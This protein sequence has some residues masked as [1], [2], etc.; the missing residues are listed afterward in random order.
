VT[1]RVLE[2]AD[3]PARIHVALESLQVD[4]P[5][6][7]PV[8]IPLEDL[9]VLVLSHPQAQITSA[10]LQAIA[11][12]GGAVLVCDAKHQPAGLLLPLQ[13]HFIQAERMAR[14]AAVAL[15]LKK[16]LWQQII[17]AKVGAQANLL[18]QLRGKDEGLGTL[19]RQIRSGDAGNLEAQAARRYWKALFE[20]SEFKR[21]REAP[22]QNRFL[23]YGY[24]VLRAQVARSICASGLHPALGLQH[25][26]R[27]SA[28]PLAD[29][30]MEPYRPFVDVVAVKLS[31]QIDAE[32]DMTREIRA[33]LLGVLHARVS[34]GGEQL[35]LSHAVLKSAQSL[36]S[37]LMG[38]AR[39]LQFPDP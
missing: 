16:R 31:E 22:D 13:G 33:E 15:P 9:G 14:Q 27:Y 4:Q 32:A 24:A 18:R 10:A 8:R 11:M 26:N 17:K 12:S 23:N 35:R 34:L 20:D 3:S 2:V 29:D 1:D 7:D 38:K 28:F 5:G 21:D 19:A 30:L 6:R 36:A 37:A 39:K 25:H